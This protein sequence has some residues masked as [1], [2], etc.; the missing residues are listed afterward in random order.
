MSKGDQI[1]RE[2]NGN[3]LEG[4]SANCQVK[5]IVCVKALQLGFWPRIPV[6]AWMSGGRGRYLPPPLIPVCRP[7]SERLFPL[8]CQRPHVQVTVAPTQFSC[9][10]TARVR[11]SLKQL[12]A[13]GKISTTSVRR[14][15]SSIR[16]SS[17]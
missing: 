11:I 3:T 1:S 16:R 17:I 14:L 2:V 8:F 4:V 10:S 12:A 13:F 6:R 5:K 9:I 15:H 7:A